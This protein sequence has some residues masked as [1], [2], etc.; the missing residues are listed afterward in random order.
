MIW[1]SG[2]HNNQRLH[3]SDKYGNVLLYGKALLFPF[4]HRWHCSVAGGRM[5]VISGRVCSG[6]SKGL[7]PRL[8]Y[9]DLHDRGDTAG[10]FFDLEGLFTVKE[11]VHAFVEIPEPGFEMMGL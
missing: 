1:I 3:L 2:D 5:T 11:L 10:P 9:L 6:L 4:F 8:L 7:L